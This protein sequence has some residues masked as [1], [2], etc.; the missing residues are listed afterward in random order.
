ML[1]ILASSGRLD[2]VPNDAASPDLGTCPQC[3]SDRVRRLA[4]GYPGGSM[5]EQASR[6]EIILG[7]CIMDR[8]LEGCSLGCL[9]CQATFGVDGRVF[10]EGIR[11]RTD[12]G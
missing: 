9:D 5:I 4:Y 1:L 12:G 3:G 6:G 7:G 8:L 11:R 2:A 10:D